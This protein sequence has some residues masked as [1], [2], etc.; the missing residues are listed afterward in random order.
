[1][2]GNAVVVGSG[3][4]GLAAAIVLAQSGLQVE[5]HETGATVGGGAR[6]GEITLPGFMHDLGS[7]VHPM[8]VSS[9]F[10]RTLPLADYGLEWVWPG[11]ALAHPLDDGTAVM[12]ERDLDATTVQFDRATARAYRALYEPLVKGWDT[13]IPE[14]L[15]PLR[16]PRHPFFLAQF[17]ARALQP[18][19]LLI[20][21]SFRD[22]RARALFAGIA[23]H[24]FLRLEAPLSS[25]FGMLLGAAGHTVG[26]PVP[27]GGA[28]QIAN[29]LA[30]VLKSFGGRIITDSRIDSLDELG[31][32]DLI[33][34]DVTPRQ[35]AKLAVHKLRGRP[36]LQLLERYR[37]GPGVFKVDWALREAIPWRAKECLRA[38]T[39]H[40]GNS[41]EEIAAYERTTWQTQPGAKPFIILVQPSLCDPTRAPAGHHTA[42]AY[43]HV[44]NGWPHPM[45]EEIEAQIERFAPGFRDCVLGRAVHTPQSLEAWN[46]N[47]VGGDLNGGAVNPM[48]FFFRPT[49]RTYGTPLHGVYLCSSSTPPGGAV[50]GMCGYN[51]AQRALG[52]LKKK[53]RWA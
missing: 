27:R 30:G 2:Q 31:A 53:R 42:W 26:W 25:A 19:S 12:L 11:T 24:S 50:H 39:V 28:Q 52:W 41:F 35:F 3:P 18:A 33:L 37:Y 36:F 20:R 6:S 22:P 5:V 23:G 14:V 40:L 15:Q 21:S 44:P 17:G 10:F 1:M 51:A 13:L 45:L 4:N 8:A 43:C 32:R 49:W 7:A 34:C 9:P 46:A 48:Q 29:A 38:A 16:V 47:L